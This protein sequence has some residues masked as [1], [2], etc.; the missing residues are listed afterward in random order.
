MNRLILSLLAACCVLSLAAANPK[1][2]FRGAWLHTVF[3]EQYRKQST[4][5][6]QAYLRSQLDKLKAA[7]VNAVVFQ[8]R[9]Q[10]DAFYPSNLEPWSR[11]LTDGGKT[12][13]P[14]WDPLRFMIDECHAR[15]ME[16]H[17]W[18]NPYRVT[19]SEKQT[20]PAKHIYHKH[21]EWFVRY[22]GKL[23]FDPGLPESRQF[24][25]DVVRDIVTRY[26]VDA[27]HFD[28]YFYPYPVEGQQFPDKSSY[29]RYGNGMNIGDWRRKN[30]DLLIES[31][32]QT[33]SEAAPGTLFSISP[34]GIWR[35]KSSDPRGSK[36]NGLQNYDALY[37][38]VLL[39]AENGWIDYLV[40]QLYWSLENPRASYQ[41]LADWWNEYNPAAN[42]N[43][44]IGQ[45][46]AVTMK[47]PDLAPST[48]PNQ[49]RHK[50]GIT[51]ALP[52][53]EGN[54]WWPGYSLTANTGGIADSLARDLQAT[55]AMMPVYHFTAVTPAEPVKVKANGRKITWDAPTEADADRADR[56]CKYAVYRFDT[57]SDIDTER[58][59]AFL[60]VTWKREWT[61]DR[62]GVY[63]VTSLNRANLESYPAKPVTVK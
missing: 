12:P 23:Y 17:A 29:A 25:N 58:P 35:N 2:E 41:V 33:I 24:I 48:D 16:L 38:D 18:L 14:A 54:C 57:V 63:V 40:P 32:H 8:V 46:I 19:T 59:E 15:G 28:D 56:A 43:L 11:F 13:S 49:L 5:E 52:G 30:V 6:N 47:T 7:G 50:V 62:P 27:I 39:W 45:D 20:L 51:R 55:P 53:I 21:P 36:T 3:Q 22:G 4:A 10:A 60:G 31:L 61:A 9:P 44:Y 26:D 37:A 42:T 34:F 1:R